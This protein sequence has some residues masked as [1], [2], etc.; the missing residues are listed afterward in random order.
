MKSLNLIKPSLL[1]LITLCFTIPGLHA[2]ETHSPAIHDFTSVSV[3]SG[4]ELIITQG[5]SE[6]AKILAKANLFDEVLIE[7]VGTNVDVRWRTPIG[8][9]KV[10]RNRTAKVFITYKN[11]NSITAGSGSSLKTENTLKASELTASVSSGAIIQ[12]NIDCEE[13]ELHTNSGSSAS[14]SGKVAKL[15][16]EAS[17][18]GIV[19]ALDLVA[20]YAKVTSDSGASVKINVSKELETISNSGGSIQYKGDATLQDLSRSKNGHVKKIN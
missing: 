12:A 10:W 20:N 18:G 6:S 15:K 11:L 1:L 13:L 5:D 8:S 3:N 17:S 16:L 19:N 4:I 9:K 14:F 2:Q 7:Q